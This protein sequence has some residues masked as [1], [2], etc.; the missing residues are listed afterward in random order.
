MILLSSFVVLLLIYD[1]KHPRIS[2]RNQKYIIEFDTSEEIDEA[3]MMMALPVKALKRDTLPGI[4]RQIHRHTSTIEGKKIKRNTFA[5]HLPV[6]SEKYSWFPERKYD[7]FAT[8]IIILLKSQTGAC[9]L[10]ITSDKYEYKIPGKN[11]RLKKR[12]DSGKSNAAN[13]VSQS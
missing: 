10:G 8:A 1:I 12:D 6:K 2:A 9:T 7:E 5:F 4:R 13:G 11:I 3:I